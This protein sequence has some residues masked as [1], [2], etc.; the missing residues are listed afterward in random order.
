M[1]VRETQA[2]LL[3]ASGYGNADGSAGDDYAGYLCARRT[4]A[5]SAWHSCLTTALLGRFTHHCHILETG[6]ESYRFLHSSAKAREQ[7][8][9]GTVKAQASQAPQ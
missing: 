9:K 3:R 6:N 1:A 2:S 7:T 8:R 4:L 5:S